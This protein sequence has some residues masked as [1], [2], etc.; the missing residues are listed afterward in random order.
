[1]RKGLEAVGS[2]PA[3]VDVKLPFAMTGPKTTAGNGMFQKTKV[4]GVRTIGMAMASKYLPS[5]KNESRRSLSRTKP[6]LS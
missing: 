1:M 2:R 6:L 5:M 3:G 4:Y